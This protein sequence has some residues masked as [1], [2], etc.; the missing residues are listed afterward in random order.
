MP[1]NAQSPRKKPPAKTPKEIESCEKVNCLPAFV[2][3]AAFA[4][5]LSAASV[6]SSIYW[7][8]KEV[9]VSPAL[10]CPQ[11]ITKNE[12]KKR[13]ILG[14]I[15]Q[16]SPAYQDMELELAAQDPKDCACRFALSFFTGSNPEVSAPLVCT[17]TEKQT[18]Q[19]RPSAE[20]MERYKSAYTPERFEVALAH[21]QLIVA[22]GERMRQV[23]PDWE[24][25]SK[26]ARWGGSAWDWYGPKQKATSDSTDLEELDGGSLFYSY[27]KIMKWPHSLTSHFPFKLCSK[28]CD[29][30]V[31]VAHT[32]EFREKYQPWMY[33]PSVKQENEKGYSFFHGFSASREEIENASHA[34]VWIRPG[35]RTKV[36]D[37][38]QTRVYLNSLERA[39]AASLIRSNG[40]VGKFNVVLDGSGFSIGLTPSLHHV[41]VFVTMLQDHYPDRLGMILLANLG[42]VGEVVVKMFLPIISEEVRNK[43]V[44]LPK[45]PAERQEILNAVVGYEN[46]PTWLGGV[47]TYQFQSE[48]YYADEQ[49]LFSDEEAKAY[50]ETMPY[51]A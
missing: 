21:S 44:V 33:S 26:N 36:D 23:V 22:L 19:R 11:I 48:E 42:R 1:R 4:F 32:L 43:I 47:D 28:G 12:N 45:D 51:H 27:L 3:G 7:I 34:V 14:A 18:V 38:A 41:K 30:T 15:R 46:S 39:V 16:K 10:Q 40:R 24:E 5:I 2:L 17:P 35:L 20:T 8:C 29:S 25:R 6:F 13:G 49:F 37:T 31:A 50:I 9:P